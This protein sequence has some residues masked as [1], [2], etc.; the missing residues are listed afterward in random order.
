MT[1][2]IITF[3][4][5][6]SAA[7]KSGPSF[8]LPPGK[9]CH[10]DFTD[11]FLHQHGAAKYSSVIMTENGFL[12]IE[13]WQ[14]I[15]PKLCDGL[16]LMVEQEGAKY[17]IDAETCGRLK[18]LLGF[19]GVGPHW[20]C[21]AELVHFAKRNVLCLLED[22]DSSAINQVGMHFLMH[23]K[24]LNTLYIINVITPAKLNNL[25]NYTC[26]LLTSLL[27]EQERLE[28]PKFWTKFA[29]PE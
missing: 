23:N 6:G 7:G 27:R 17:G 19:D 4:R 5:S 26:R 20:K 1:L 24:K 12:T 22:R 18:I 29:A 9:V 2:V 21:L 25:H 28:A 10:P 13:A 3:I 11:E 14:E 8:L 16:R 15:V